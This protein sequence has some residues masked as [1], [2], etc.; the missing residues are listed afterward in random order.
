VNF[1]MLHGVGDANIATA[2]W[3]FL[4]G[5]AVR[6]GMLVLLAAA[7]LGIWSRNSAALR[8]MVWTVVCSGLVVLPALQLVVPSWRVPILPAVAIPAFDLVP[9]ARMIH[10][11]RGTDAAVG[12]RQTSVAGDWTEGRLRSQAFWIML[13]VD[14]WGLGVLGV[15]IVSLANQRRTWRFVETARPLT[16]PHVLAVLDHASRIIALDRRVPIREHPLAIPMVCGVF[17]PVIVLPLSARTWGEARLRNVL[18]HELA[19]IRRSDSL[20]QMVA[21]LAVALYWFNPLVW[22][23][24]RALRTEREHACDDVVLAAGCHP[25]DYAT[26]LIDLTQGFQSLSAAS[27]TGLAFVRLSQ[28]RTRVQAILGRGRCRGLVSRRGAMA[29]WGAGFG[30]VCPLVGVTLQPSGNQWFKHD[31]HA[32][33]RAGVSLYG[34]SGARPEHDARAVCDNHGGIATSVGVLASSVCRDASVSAG[35]YVPRAYVHLPSYN[36]EIGIMNK[37]K[38][39]AI[40]GSAA[41]VI[42]AGTP[43]IAQAKA[44]VVYHEPF[45]ERDSVIAI[46]PS[47]F[48]EV[49]SDTIVIKSGQIASLLAMVPKDEQ[50]NLSLQ[51]DS[52][53]ISGA[54]TEA[55]IDGPVVPVVLEPGGP[56]LVINGVVTT[57][58]SFNLDLR[59]IESIA[60][61]TG[62]Q[63]VKSYGV[64]AENGVIVVTTR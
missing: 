41:A 14:G 2:I 27:V 57:D 30:V 61:V 53:S 40:L 15:L 7:V 19:H 9:R 44:H 42:L 26:D 59:L 18:L 33:G 31:S 39:Q 21:V 6:G 64:E 47:N 50:A 10:G 24:V 60:V 20:I 38:G 25:R 45:V 43:M 12:Q 46:D 56:L 36:K 17:R 23:A 3:P 4:V 22:V 1:P 49:R 52:A 55:G 5:T 58:R 13:V 8:H 34:A 48:Y 63:A 62:T 51:M 37:V 16:T 32:G 29:V 35:R 28:L 11:P 54:A